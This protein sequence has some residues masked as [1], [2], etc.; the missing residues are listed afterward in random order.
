[1]DHHHRGISTSEVISERDFA[2]RVTRIDRGEVPTRVGSISAA[3]SSSGRRVVGQYVCRMF[4]RRILLVVLVVLLPLACSRGDHRTAELPPR[5]GTASTT[6]TAATSSIAIPTSAPSDIHM[7]ALIRG[8]LNSDGECFWIGAKP[9]STVVIWPHGYHAATNPLR[10]L[11]NNGHVFARIGEV[12]SLGGGGVP[13]NLTALQLATTYP[14]L[15]KCL[16]E[17]AC[18][19]HPNPQIGCLNDVWVV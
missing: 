13:T 1:M 4:C 2:E 6:A 14:S 16:P 12:I 18:Y 17:M 7:D 3:L 10:I 15:R 19:S 9:H 8:Q 11:D 5:T